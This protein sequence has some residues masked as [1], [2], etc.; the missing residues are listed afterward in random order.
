MVAVE[1][2]AGS[3]DTVLPRTVYY[4][5]RDEFALIAEPHGDFDGDG[6]VDLADHDS[7]TVCFTGPDGWPISTECAPGDSDLDEDIDCQDWGVFAD[8]VDG[9]L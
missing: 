8:L 4:A 6:N 1:A 7:F 3:C 5:R 2:N 9:P